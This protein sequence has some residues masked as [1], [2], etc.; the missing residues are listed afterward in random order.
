MAD[1]NLPQ[2]L[3]AALL[4]KHIWVPEQGLAYALQSSN[5][6]TKA[7]L[8]TEIIDYL[9]QNQKEEALQKALAAVRTITPGIARA[10]ALRVLVDKLPELLPE[11]LAA[12]RA[13]QD[14]WCRAKALIALAPKLP[15]ELL[16]EALA[17]ARD[18]HRNSDYCRV[19]ALR[20]LADKLPELLPEA[21]AAAR[22]MTDIEFE[23]EWY[24]ADA[25]RVLADKLPEL[26]P[27]LLEL[28]DQCRQGIT[29]IDDDDWQDWLTDKS[30]S[31]KT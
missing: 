18:R 12:I 14:E 21:L 13:I 17:I 3:L 28:L 11:A 20:V 7:S 30:L 16:P 10:D 26:L 15:P 27:E 6:Q 25:L 1:P 29:Y 4:Q 2:G 22:A 9:P 24:H 8:L 5:P 31:S 19:H 23:G